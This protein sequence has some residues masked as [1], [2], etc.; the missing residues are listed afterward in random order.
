MSHQQDTNE[1][2]GAMAKN[3]DT[4]ICQDP[5]WCASA[6]F[7]DIVLP[8]TTTLERN[9]ITSGGTYSNDKVYAMRQV[10]EPLGESLDDFEIFRRLGDH[11]G[12]GFGFTEGK[13]VMDVVKAGYERSAATMPFEQFWE[14]GV[15]LVV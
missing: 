12:V 8:A 15:A 11:L 4:V 3:I 13:Q 7:A 6:R 10:I 14:E 1:L 2:I 9:D 5:W